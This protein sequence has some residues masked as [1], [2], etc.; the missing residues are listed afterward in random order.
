VVAGKGHETVQIVGDD[1]RPFDDR[2]HL[3]T[4]LA[5]RRGAAAMGLDLPVEAA[6]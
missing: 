3:R 6:A 5:R 4:A 2:D 1:V